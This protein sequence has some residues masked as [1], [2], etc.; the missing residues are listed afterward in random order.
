MSK[1]GNGDCLVTIGT[2][3]VGNVGGPS[4]STSLDVNPTCFGSANGR[5]IVV[6]SG[7]TTPLSY[8]ISPQVGTV[9]ND[10]DF[11]NLP[12][13][14]YTF[15]V[16]D[17]NGCTATVT[18]TLTNP[19]VVVANAG[20]DRSIC[21]G[22]STT[23]TASA[24]GGTGTKTFTWM[25]GSLSGA[26]IT[27]SPTSNQNYTVTATDANGCMDT[28]VATVTVKPLP[29]A[30]V[31]NQNVCSGSSITF[32]APNNPAGT[33]YAWT[34]GANASPATATGAGPHT[35][36][37][38]LP[39]TPLGNGSAVVNLTA[40]R[41]GC[42]VSDNATIGI[43]DTPEGTLT[44]TDATCGNNNGTVTVTFPDNP[45]R[46]GVLYTISGPTPDVGGN[47]DVGS[48]TFT[49]LAPGNYQISGRW[50]DGNCSVVIG[51]ITVGNV[52]GPS[53]STSLDVNPTCFGSANGRVIVVGSGG[54]T[55][56]SYSISPQV[57]TVVND[58]DFRNLP[59]GTY[60]FTVTDANGC[61][62]TVTRTLTNPAIVVANAG[63][64]RSI[65]LGESTTLTAS[66][67][68]GTGTKTFTWMPGNLSGA[69]ITV[70]PTSNQNY[71]VTAT[72]A[73]GCTDTDVATVT[74]K[75]LPTA[76]VA[77]QAVC[78][79]SS[80]TFTAPANPGG[81]TYAWNFGANASP[82]TATGA[83][84]HVVTYAL[85]ANQLGNGTATV[86][87]TATRNGC[88]DQGDATVTILDT[89][90]A[91]ITKADATCGDNNGSIT[92]TFPDNPNRTGIQFSINGTDFANLADNTGSYTFTGVAPGTY[93]IT[94]RWG[95]LDC[96]VTI[97]TITIN[98]VG[99]PS[100]TAAITSNPN[101]FGA[102]TGR[103]V[104]AGTTTGTA[105]FTYS[106]SPQ[107]GTVVNARDFR[108]LPAGTYTFT[109]TDANGCTATVTRTL[110]NPAQL[111]AAAGPDKSICV[112]ESTTLTA[113]AAGGAGAKTYTWMPGNLTGAT[114]TVSP[115]ATTNYTV[116]ATDA[117]GCTDTDV[118]TVTV[119][120]LPTATV[121][122]QA[123]C[124]GS[125]VTFTAPSNPAGTTYAWDFGANASPA[126]ATGAGPHTVTYTLPSSPLGNGSS[127]VSLTATRNGC[128][129][130][131]NATIGILDTPEG[132]LTR[133]NATCGD[134]NGTITVTFPDNP[135][136]GGVQFSINGTNFANLADD[137]GSY[138]FSGLAPGN[139]TVTGR[140]GDGNCSVTI[141]TITINNVGGPSATAAITSNPN[142]FGAATGRVVIA[143]TTTGTAPF[144]YSISPQAGT[145]VN[146]RDFRNL[147]AGTYTFTVTDANGCT[148]TVTRTLTN[149]AQLVAAAGPDK[150]ICVGE[151]TTLT[152]S[153]AGG[154]GAKTYTWMPG[155]LTGATITVSPIAT[156]NY[157]VTATDANGCTDTDVATVT[158]KPLPTATVANQAV[159]SGSTVTFTAPSNPAGT[160]YAWNF[161]A[162]ASPATATGAGPHVVTYALP[163]N[164]LGNGTAT[165]SLTATLSGCSA[166]DNATVTILDTPA[167]TLTKT[168]A[169][170]GDDNGT[171]TVTFP[172]N[173]DRTGIQFSVNGTSFANLADNIGSYTFS[174][175]SPGVYTITGRW[176]GLD[177]PVTI[178][179]ITVGNVGGPTAATQTVTNPDCFGAA[180]GRVL[181]V[182]ST[183]GTAPFTYSINPQAGTVV[184]ARDFRNLPAGTYTFTVTDAN[185]CTATVTRTL[186]N[187]AQLVA[188]AGPD[189]SICVGESTTLTASATG[190]TGTKT[191]SWMP[192]NLTG[193]TI[194]VSPTATTNYT[195]TATDANGC[196]DTDVA[197]VTV[198]PLPTATV[199]NQGLC[200]G[201]SITF[202]APS[203]PAGTTYAWDFGANASPATATGAGPHTVTYTLPV[204][205]LGNG[206]AT[207]S[208]TATLSGCSANDEATITIQD[209]PEG[210]L[211]KTDATCGDDNGTITV[212]FPDNPDR[213]GIQF[214]SDGTN[215]ISNILDD[216]GSYTFSGLAPGIYEI[217]SRWG[218]GQCEVSL[219]S[220][221]INNIGG[222]TATASVTT[223]PD[224]FGA[225]TGRVVI[226]G[227]TTGTAPFT[228]SINPQAGTVVNARDFR[229]LP[230]GTYTFTVTDA[231]GCTATVTRT[232]TN[233]AQLV[234]AAGPDKSIC[235]GE[236]TTL[237]AS[238]AGGAGAKTYTWMPGNLTG[239]TITVSPI[240]TTNYTVTATDA[241][242]CTDTDVATVTVKPLPTATVAN[243]AV[244][245]GSTVTFTA[246]SNPAGTTY[247]WNFGANASPA[248][249]T[250]AGPHVVTYALP[251]NQLGNGTATV[252]LT[253]T[254]S[255]CSAS[256]NATVTILDT[257][258]GTLTKTDATCGD[259]NGTITV[260]FPDNPDRTGIQ[261]SVN[262]TS[263]ANLADN[264]GSY[265]FSNLS[266]GVYTITGRWGGLDCPVT[267]GTIT[268][269]NVGGP[270][271]ATQTVTNPDCFGAATGRVL[272]VASTTGT[273]PFTYSINPQA[274]TVV[275][276]R[277]FRNL[278]AGT[279]TFT[280]T[281][282]NGCTATVTRTL[283]NP[284]QLVAAAGPDK[285]ICVGESTTLTAS[286]TGGTGTKTYSWMP[287]NL[288]GA[289]ITVSPTAT[290]NYTVTAT[291]ANGCTDTDVATVTVKPLPTATV[292]NQ[293]LCSGSSITFT[294]PSNPAGTTYAWDFGANASPATATGAGPHTVTYTLPVNQLG[295]GTATV[296]LTA[297][298]SGCS[299]NDEATI[300]IQ[301]TP[302]GTLTKTDATCGDD[303]GTITVTFPDNPDRNGI[304]FSSDGTNFISNIL[305]DSGSYTF[306]GLAPGIYEITSRWGNG[307]CEVSLGSITIN[308]I[309]GPTATASVTTNPDCFGANTGRVVIAGSTT[310]TAPFTYSINPQAGTVVNARDFR[311]LPAGTYTFTVTDANGCT[312]TVTRTLTN[313][314]Q[315]V[316]AAG[317][318]K[319]ICV[320]ESTTLTASA[321][322]GTGTKTYSWM[323]G[324][325]TGATITVSPTATTNY[326][327]TATDA[328]GCTDTDVATVTIKPLPT[329]TV[330]NQAVCS[331]SS[332]TFTAPAN[333]GG[334]TY[335]WNFG[336]NAS[337]ATATGA[338]PHVV[339][340]ALPVNQLGNGT[341]TVSLT[342]TR[343]GCS[344]SD[345][346]T[347]TILDT[348]EGTL[349]KT[350]ATCGDDNGTIT[351]T[352]PDNP[353]QFSLL[354]QL[355][356]TNFTVGGSD[357]ADSYTFT[358]LTAGTYDVSGEWGN[359]TCPVNIGTITI[360]S[361]G[362]PNAVVEL[363]TNPGCIN[364]ETGRIII[365]A[366]TTGTA[367]FTY[368]ISPQVGT[369]INGRDFREL[370]AG[371]YTFMVTD[372]NGCTATVTRTLANPSQL[373]ANTDP[374]KNICEGTTTTLTAVASGGT[375]DYSYAWSFNASTNPIL[376]DVVAGTY[377]VTITDAN[378]CVATASTMVS[379]FTDQNVVI[380]GPAEICANEITTY[381]VSPSVTG[382][383][384]EWTFNGPSFP[385]TATGPN[386]MVTYSAQ[387]SY[388][389]ELTTISA[390]GC[391]TSTSTSVLVR[392]AISA[393][394]GG[395]LVVCQGGSVTIDASNS[396][397]TSYNWV[398]ATGDPT[399][400]DGS[401]TSQTITVS[402][403][404]L[405]TYQLTV[406]DASGICVRVDDVR[407]TV[408][409]NLNPVANATVSD[410]FYCQG[411]TLTLDAS[412]TLAPAND[413]NANLNFLWFAGPPANGN[414]VGLGEM[415]DVTADENTL[416]YFVIV[417]A[418]GNGTTCGDTASVTI[419][420]INCDATLGD[421]AFLDVNGD[422]IFTP[423]TDQGLP[424][425][426]VSLT[427]AAGNPVADA[428]G[429][430]VADQ[431]TDGNGAYLF[432]NLV[433]GDYIVTF[434]NPN[435]AQQPTLEN[436]NGSADDAEN[437]D[438]DIDATGSTDVITLSS[439]ENET[440]IDAGYMR[441]PRLA[442]WRSWTL[443]ATVFSPPARTRALPALPSA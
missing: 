43:L 139:Y 434:T 346:A 80:I 377:T 29:T 263:F 145:V 6:G 193:A 341:A 241:N 104:I 117:N 48:Y 165:V 237:T 393:D 436:V 155:N 31:A 443:T 282:A 32:T 201:S 251:V 214:S 253:A 300:T 151:S 154:A 116:T 128:S 354:F 415:L 366:S 400:I 281:D 140:W 185:G 437:N 70:S 196:T 78:S 112:G 161:G 309:G 392:E 264:I 53:A 180:T 57:G 399:S 90:A 17:A 323:P 285:S 355:V 431:T 74:V 327:V 395:D 383:T 35:V 23:L 60:T 402:P 207:V 66:A 5:V 168:D 210:T 373:T 230:A 52:G 357:N 178:G 245:S 423:G 266:P 363:S 298:L 324:N 250:G 416:E 190:G 243:Q 227:S 111:V 41:N 172:D 413:P 55:P 216:S 102:A 184:N 63:P 40:T 21:L 337:P 16:T 279:Y 13:G 394:A 411:S 321:T 142:C 181:V 401:T 328:N 310:G 232:L 275:N 384:Y 189:K 306:S 107:A 194:T 27:V 44:K 209:T 130:S 136:R 417:S 33:T 229:N 353:D 234:A 396:V 162:N 4:A 9:V 382:S 313:P 274:G 75:P 205:Q 36:T 51:S 289:T 360:N 217:T 123:V 12:A 326:T 344:A 276:A 56:L 240:A 294:A 314:A 284:A 86:S 34:F 349:T 87:L 122:N 304:Q 150:S 120:P 219:G 20:P 88:S 246:P 432:T 188:A 170:C 191:Y 220:I 255:G 206:T 318:N 22:E 127:V 50:G 171:I 414:F 301:D 7:G 25:P 64:D 369:L 91:T 213:N 317:P 94:S 296:S 259:D 114:I 79:G 231:N 374:D 47:D 348:P 133:T 157:T 405:T 134:N 129:A 379:T 18:R 299:A 410:N 418:D 252:S 333:P 424:G 84:P 280:V 146:A 325:L 182:A 270:T 428:S 24:T 42:S 106:I 135:D 149:P 224:C 307:Q 322:G 101:C 197:T 176:G 335:A 71:T 183:T 254:L 158:V 28:N 244:C 367:P 228:Y 258:A 225:N 199:A 433:P 132:T 85:P 39:A 19:A 98:N 336:A 174:N 408:D 186:T 202:T 385:G 143:G 166:S 68:G 358:G 72:D 302:E 388:V 261:F 2:I 179:T 45:D 271:A 235:V 15:T 247:A 419:N 126:T 429:V 397:G 425:V 100:A 362:G 137:A 352:F 99:G 368:S 390:E 273:A 30:T 378:N 334:T 175:L 371:T 330:A 212:T 222:P 272:V 1:W 208:L 319:S 342:A 95:G 118:A 398:V 152:A 46:L 105:P 11:R 58:R 83:G 198:K 364:D 26:T 269:G 359:N 412:G 59:A 167:G 109:V 331:G 438:S 351:V 8:S 370:P 54:T 169:T 439:G 290:T 350:D 238:A 329:A 347:V 440:D 295:N 223:N 286:A 427:D 343:N 93:T 430:T 339:T 62:A 312:A 14:T 119:K 442:I 320:G 287:G 89:P 121:A 293:G 115:I 97:G 141:G 242:G 345:N 407:V 147:P 386:P 144:T 248:T 249:A 283:T 356:G 426:T 421:L 200:S 380:T 177:C 338:G 361:I 236:S 441:P 153:A 38:T 156:T 215:F 221:T 387:G 422:G 108:N 92:V 3:T 76:T 376:T 303:N 10:R 375:P 381:S 404:F 187:P 332:I 195:V 173:P 67:T 297:T 308:N 278:P 82:A 239:A 435:A 218:N 262:G 61:T 268:V 73:N 81:T 203:N 204:N 365:A 163:V 110:T 65:C 305:D 160:T 226:A 77:N 389:I 316:A 420:I 103:V 131:D 406:R 391:S 277:D 315:L 49:G 256:D 164:Q 372:A 69:T 257:P 124:S 125:T 409:V 159:C 148:A 37:Y 288:T 265:T 260:T 96:L 192:G 138:T 267:I 233:P 211:T 403:L 311:N 340:Y 291:D 113:S 292:A